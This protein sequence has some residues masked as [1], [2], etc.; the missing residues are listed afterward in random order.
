MPKSPR[1]EIRPADVIGAAVM[2]ARIATGE[3]RDDLKSGRVKSGRGGAKARLK[4]LTG[5]QRGAV[6]KKAAAARWRP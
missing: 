3:I 6:A 1:G 4:V 2:V 5:E